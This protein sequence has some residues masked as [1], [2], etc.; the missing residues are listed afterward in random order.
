[1][2]ALCSSMRGE[3]IDVADPLIF[4]CRRRAIGIKG[5]PSNGM[6]VA[7]H[8]ALA[9]EPGGIP[10]GRKRGT[11]SLHGADDMA[12]PGESEIQMAQGGLAG[13]FDFMPG[14]GA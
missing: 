11:G 12:D 9:V 4:V 2:G 6:E 8:P 3:G 5:A 13:L 1:M 10:R 7:A 14:R